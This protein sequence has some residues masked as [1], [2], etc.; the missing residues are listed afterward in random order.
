MDKMTTHGRLSALTILTAS[1]VFPDPLEP[2]IPMI[3]LRIHQHENIPSWTRGIFG[4]SHGYWPMEGCSGQPEQLESAW[5]VLVKKRTTTE[6]RRMEQLW[7]NT[8]EE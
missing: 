2:A 8:A 6:A 4:F 5:L 1:D 3:F 7:S